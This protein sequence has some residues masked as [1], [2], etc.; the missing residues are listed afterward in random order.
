MFVS[1]KSGI[2][3]CIAVPVLITGEEIIRVFFFANGLFFSN[4]QT[5][6]VMAIDVNPTLIVRPHLFLEVN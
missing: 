6:R 3:V 2:E 5:T 4:R 1:D